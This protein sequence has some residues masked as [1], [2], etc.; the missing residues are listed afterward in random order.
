MSRREAAGQL[1]NQIKIGKAIR[2]QRIRNR[3]ELDHARA[4]K[5]EWSRRASETLSAIFAGGETIAEHFNEWT[6]PILPEYA[7][8]EMFVELFADEM[9][10]RLARLQE[11]QA[12]LNDAAEP[13]PIT[14]A[15]AGETSESPSQK[16]APPEAAV[17]VEA[18]ANASSLSAARQ[19]EENAIILLHGHPSSAAVDAVGG[20][21]KQLGL[22]AVAI[23]R[24]A[25]APPIE[26]QLGRRRPALAIFVDWQGGDGKPI[27]ALGWCIGR[28]G[29]QGVCALQTQSAGDAID[30]LANF[31]EIQRI[32]FDPAAGGDVW[33]LP[34]ARQLRRCGVQLDL[35]RLL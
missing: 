33:Q 18:R 30:S 16:P 10:H 27:F 35:N 3:W 29:A 25:D 34:L 7:E 22:S 20:F 31:A 9:R 17:S 28:L 15:R 8:L 5:Q 26:R 19:G 12:M 4:E 21:L 13:G 6:A 11:A 1:A 32:T 24:Q 14:S 2:S 23:W